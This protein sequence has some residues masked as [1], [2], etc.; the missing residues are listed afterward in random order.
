MIHLDR[1]RKVFPG[2]ATPAVTD[3]SLAV[4]EG[5]IVVLIG[6]SGCGKSTTLR[7]INRLIEPTS[8]SITVGGRDVAEEKPHEL[9]LRIGYVIQ[10][11]GLFPHR[12]ISQNI[13]TVPQLLGWD[14][15]RI[16]DRVAQLMELV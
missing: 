16:E 4:D 10:Q 7:M 8:G 1:V 11:V 15:S 3:L 2:S 14:R 6:P 5:E 12:T 13:A 9:R